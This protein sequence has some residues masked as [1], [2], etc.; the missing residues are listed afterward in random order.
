MKLSDQHT[1][2]VLLTD[3]SLPGM[4]G[5]A[6][7]KQLLMKQPAIQVVFASGYGAQMVQHLKF[8]SRVLPK[9]YDV[10]QIQNLLA[11]LSTPG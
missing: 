10:V 5:I 11:E 6:L 2:D 7:A 9:P 3:V 4:S 1:F 8:Q